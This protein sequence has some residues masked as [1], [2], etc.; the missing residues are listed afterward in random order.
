MSRKNEIFFS[1]R[2]NDLYEK[3]AWPEITILELAKTLIFD[4]YNQIF[5]NM[6]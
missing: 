4:N 1:F 2:N 5:Q 3:F 6:R